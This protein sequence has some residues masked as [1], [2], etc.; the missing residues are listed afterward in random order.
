MLQ[1]SCCD[2]VQVPK[3]LYELHKIILYARN[4]AKTCER[5]CSAEAFLVLAFLARSN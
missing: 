1:G 2:T 5:A 4:C 3:L